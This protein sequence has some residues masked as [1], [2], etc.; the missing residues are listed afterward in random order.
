MNE[1]TCFGLQW[2]SSGFHKQLRLVYII[3]VEGVLMKR[4]LCINPLFALVSSVNRLY[5]SSEEVPDFK[6]SPC[7]VCCM[8]SFG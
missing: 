4:S 1:T 3:C 6:L 8:L 7:S 5:I 2:P